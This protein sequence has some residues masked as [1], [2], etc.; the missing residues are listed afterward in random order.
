MGTALSTSHL[1]STSLRS[2][3]MPPFLSRTLGI[4]RKPLGRVQTP[5]V[6]PTARALWC[7]RTGLRFPELRTL[8][9]L[10]ITPAGL[11]LR[12][13]RKQAC[14]LRKAGERAPVSSSRGPTFPTRV[15]VPPPT[16]PPFTKFSQFLSKRLQKSVG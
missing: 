14:G 5:G 7:F 4:F 8:C 6:V 16:R 11:R 10:T 15:L 9:G 13:S 12:R 3:Q 1:L 2:A